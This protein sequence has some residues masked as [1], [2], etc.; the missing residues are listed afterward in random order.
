MPD[1][2]ISMVNSMNN[3]DQFQEELNEIYTDGILD[4]N[5]VSFTSFEYPKRVIQAKSNIL[6]FPYNW[7][8]ILQNKMH[9]L[10]KQVNTYM[11]KAQGGH[12]EKWLSLTNYCLFMPEKMEFPSLI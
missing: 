6:L 12:R 2:V 10:L 3:E 9:E 7:G 1:R 4:S 5:A 8:P 11:S